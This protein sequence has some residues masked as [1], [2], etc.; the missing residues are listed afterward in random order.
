MQHYKH[1]NNLVSYLTR[2]DFP[3]EYPEL[4]NFVVNSLTELIKMMKNNP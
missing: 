3:L 2:M 1:F 4:Y